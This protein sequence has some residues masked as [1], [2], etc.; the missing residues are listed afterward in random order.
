MLAAPAGSA[1][2]APESISEEIEFF[3]GLFLEVR[4]QGNETLYRI[5]TISEFSVVGILV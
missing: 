1:A 4:M 3:P 5:F 2:S